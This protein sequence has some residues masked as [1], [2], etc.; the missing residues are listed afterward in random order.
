MKVRMVG[1]Q[2]KKGKRLEAIHA[3]TKRQ[4][5]QDAR[6]ARDEPLRDPEAQLLPIESSRPQF[7]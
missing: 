5:S 3:E 7:R 1:E 4:A 2:E 6:L